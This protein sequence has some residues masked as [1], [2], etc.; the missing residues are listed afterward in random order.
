MCVLGTLRARTHVASAVGVSLYSLYVC[1]NQS[2]YQQTGV[3]FV[4]NECGMSVE[5]M[6]ESGRASI[7]GDELVWNSCVTYAAAAFAEV[8]C[9]AIQRGDKTTCEMGPQELDLGELRSCRN[10]ATRRTLLCFSIF[11]C[12][13]AAHK[14][15][16]ANSARQEISHPLPPRN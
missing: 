8:H 15:Q 12:V 9:P 6:S 10:G 7:V 3:E 1:P 13:A 5:S 4:S 2:A 14:R 11:D 16:S